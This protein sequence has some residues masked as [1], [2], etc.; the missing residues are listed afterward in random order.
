LAA[1]NGG[2][3]FGVLNADNNGKTGQHAVWTKP[4]KPL[5]KRPEAVKTVGYD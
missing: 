2:K 5:G 3:F 4:N 1:R